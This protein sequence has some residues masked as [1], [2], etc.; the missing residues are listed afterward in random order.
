MTSSKAGKGA[1]DKTGKRNL[2]IILT[3]V[4][5]LIIVVLVS[6]MKVLGNNWWQSSY[7]IFRHALELIYFLSGVVLIVGL[8]IGYKQL[9][10]TN[11]DIKIRNE[12]MAVEKSLEYL[13]FFAETLLPSINDYTR[14]I[15]NVEPMNISG[16]VPADNDYKLHLE[17]LN[18]LVNPE[19]QINI[20]E[21]LILR[22]TSGIQDI[23]N[24]LEYF[25]SGINHGLAK[26]EVVYSP[27]SSVLCRF[28]EKEIIPLCVTRASRAPFENL[29]KLYN[30][31]DLRMKND[32][33]RLQLEKELSIIEDTKK[34]IAA[35]EEIT[36]PQ[37]H[38][39][40]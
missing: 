6:V 34:Q 40:S 21:Q 12:R 24:Q 3:S 9:E 39:G 31:W 32:T 20:L 25:C 35:A 30:K 13:S 38:I 4:I 18:E 15:G 29:L 16:W 5:I 11:K 27:I 23:F 28:V 10:I 37:N 1:T 8:Y 2:G 14:R 19:D 33:R 36:K 17:K 22:E 26:E 7:D